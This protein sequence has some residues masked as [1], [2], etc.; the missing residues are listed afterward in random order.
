MGNPSKIFKVPE[1][2]KIENTTVPGSETYPDVE[3][4]IPGGK[5][6][7][8]PGYSLEEVIFES[9]RSRIWRG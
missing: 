4:M 6:P 2:S 5:K 1:R 7:V 3:Q 8:I 9:S